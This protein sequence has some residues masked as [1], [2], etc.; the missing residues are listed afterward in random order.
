MQNY[1]T[2]KV[3][4]NLEFEG[5]TLISAENSLDYNTK[6]KDETGN[7]YNVITSLKGSHFDGKLEVIKGELL[8]N[9]QNKAEIEVAQSVGIAV[10]PY[11]ITDEGELVSSNGNLLLMDENT[12]TL[13]LPESVTS[14]GEGA[15]ADLEGLKTIII[16][17]TVKEIKKEAFRGNKDL[18]T[19]IME[20]GVEIIGYNAFQGCPNL[21]NVNMPQSLKEIRNQA[22]DSDS[23]IKQITIPSGVKII[24]SYCFSS[25]T[26]LTKVIIENGVE[27]IQTSAFASCSSL[28][29]IELPESLKSMGNSVFN[30]CINL[31]IINIDPKNQYYVYENGMLLPKDKSEILFISDKILKQSST[32]EIPSGIKSFSAPINNYENITKLIIPQS[33]NY[34]NIIEIPT[35]ISAIEVDSNNTNMIVENNCLYSYDKKTLLLCFTKEK[36]V[37]LSENLEKVDGFSF[38]AASNIEE[39]ILPESVK[40]IESQVFQKNKKL[41][42]LKIGKNVSH[43]N[44][45]FKY[46]NGNGEVII[47]EENPYY[48]I[49]NNILYNKEKTELIAVIERIQG[50]FIVPENIEKIGDR[51]FHNQ[52]KMTSIEL[53]TSL[54]EIGDSFNFCN[55]LVEITIPANVEKIGNNCFASAVNLE[56]IKIN[57]PANSIEYSP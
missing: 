37:T 46:M 18:E 2:N 3:L 53:P 49:E 29:Q 40:S 32:F 20:E 24:G 14:I 52:E 55:G 54:K 13:R 25:A 28:S 27:T 38:K 6:P 42:T 4:E 10:N 8:L 50:N 51:A 22:F 39:I 44:P 1:K 36:T 16:P 5:A 45:I 9:S 41:K 34:I 30:R 26:G 12:G 43:I 35:S 7:I 15:F 17:G 57:K 11:E 47:D 33:L 48:T 23:N 19:V 31:E 21:T 56:K